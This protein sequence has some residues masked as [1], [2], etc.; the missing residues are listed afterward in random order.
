[1]TLSLIFDT[2]TTGVADFK[3]SVKDP[4]QP[5]LVELAFQLYCS[6]RDEVMSDY[7]VIVN[8]GLPV[9]EGAAKIHGISTEMAQR[10]GIKPVVALAA[11]NQALS[12]A[13]RVVGHNL[14]FD[15]FV[16]Q[17]MYM[18]LERSIEPLISKPQYCTMLKSMDI[19]KIPGRFGKHKWPRL[20]EAYK[21][22]VNE[23][24]FDGAH[25]AKFDV[26]ATVQVMKALD[27][28]QGAG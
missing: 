20:E 14:K 12:V 16:M 6:E 22:L 8:P 1:M 4:S 5:H 25:R 17:C 9:P 13:D 11:F 19:L 2:E 3:K 24:G 7:S 18:R 28:R 26:D 23:E 21:F 27:A 10:Y 15:L